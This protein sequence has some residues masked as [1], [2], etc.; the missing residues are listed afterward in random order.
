ME[1]GN[2]TRKEMKDSFFQNSHFLLGLSPT[3]QF[4]AMDVVAILMASKKTYSILCELI[5][6]QGYKYQFLIK[7]NIFFGDYSVLHF[8]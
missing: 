8:K 7:N 5:A 4:I 2:V 3:L 6:R 1:A